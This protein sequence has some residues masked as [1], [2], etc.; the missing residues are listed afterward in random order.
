M[1]PKILSADEIKY[2]VKNAFKPVCSTHQVVAE[3][4][5]NGV[6]RRKDKGNIFVRPG[7]IISAESGYIRGK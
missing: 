4:S 7:G 6:A 2:R 5:M 3:A 1:H